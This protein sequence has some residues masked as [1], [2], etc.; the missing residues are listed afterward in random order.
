MVGQW[1]RDSLELGLVVRS[2]DGTSLAAFP[3]LRGTGF[4]GLLLGLAFF[5]ASDPEGLLLLVGAE[6]G[7][8][9][10]GI[11]VAGRGILGEPGWRTGGR[12]GTV[13]WGGLWVPVR[14][15]A[16]SLLRRLGLASVWAAGIKVFLEELVA[17]SRG[18]VL[19][20]RG[21]GVTGVLWLGFTEG[22]EALAGSG[23]EVGGT[24]FLVGG[25]AFVKEG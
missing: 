19:G 16:S 21:L 12:G 4:R 1:G 9:V 22:R 25:A 18:R 24:G 7:A 8:R 17:R 23:W 2:F 14:A 10:G 6:P 15:G 13:G 11:A 3:G 20:S 5:V